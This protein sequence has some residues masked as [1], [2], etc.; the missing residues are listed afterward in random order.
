MGAVAQS[1]S[2]E[3]VVTADGRSLHA[4]VSGEGPTLLLI[5][6]LGYATWGWERQLPAALPST[7]A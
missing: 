1:W 7:S 2:D 4:E 5:Q 6:G 3:V